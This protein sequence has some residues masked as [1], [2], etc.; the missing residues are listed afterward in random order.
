MLVR[1]ALG[2]VI[3][4]ALF[5][6]AATQADA[7]VFPLSDPAD[8]ITADVGYSNR[9]LDFNGDGYWDLIGRGGVG[10]DVYLALGSPTGLMTVR[11]VSL[12]DS[13]W[14]LGL[15]VGDMTG[16]G[17]DDVVL[18]FGNSSTLVLIRGRADGQVIAPA[19]DD[20]YTLPGPPTYGYG[21]PTSVA[22]GDV[23]GD[24]DLDVAAGLG[25]KED[26]WYPPNSAETGAIHVFTNDGGGRLTPTSAT[27]A[28][29]A[30]IDVKLLSLGNDDDPELLV[31]QRNRPGAD[32]KVFAGASGAGFGSPTV[33]AAGGVPVAGDF[34]A[35]GRLDLAVGHG[36]RTPITILPGTGGG[37]GEPVPAP[38][39]GGDLAVGDLDGDGRDDLYVGTAALWDPQDLGR[40]AFLRGSGGL[41]F[42]APVWPDENH[43]PEFQPEIADLDGDGRL[44]VVARFYSVMLIRWGLGPQ[45]VPAA[46]YIDFGAQ[47]VGAPSAPRTLDFTNQ[48]GGPARNI[49]AMIEGD[50]A[51][52]QIDLGSCA[53]A[54]L[55]V[56]DTCAVS[57]R[58]A[59]T[60]VGDRFAGFGLVAR[61]SDVIWGAGLF[62]EGVAEPLVAPV[63]GPTTTPTPLPTPVATPP[64]ATLASPH[65]QPVTR[66]SLRRRGVRFRQRF[67]QAGRAR[68]TLEWPARHVL[69]S[70]RRNVTAG[71]TVTVT[72]RLTAK[73]KRTISRRRPT[74]LTLRTRFTDTRGRTSVLVTRVPL[75]K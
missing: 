10:G 11:T 71:R 63:P 50:D 27:L 18:T 74:A 37:F 42:D 5:A 25:V 20:R 19:D 38:A 52:F 43:G 3:C 22:V 26:T 24:G 75:R 9:L 13:G 8:Q 73:A 23:D 15:A 60:A 62:G 54:T 16:D 51:E 39:S 1:R 44:D 49:E 48:S 4:G 69:G 57:I 2:A 70:A 64:S 14:A 66:R 6:L 28:V 31:L 45:L 12:P 56:G 67:P 55:Q 41:H 65:L 59:P 61:D 21:A 35:D 34:D 17:R 72:I 47:T 33:Y 40:P 36:S 7:T 68:W 30:P 29:N 46:G 53:S 32:L 58:F